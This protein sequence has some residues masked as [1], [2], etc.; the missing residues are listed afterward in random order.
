M[1]QPEGFE[2][3]TTD[4]PQSGDM[5]R[6]LT[7][8]ARRYFG[9]DARVAGLERLGGGAS[10]ELWAFT[11]AA[12]D[13]S[14]GLVLR[15]NPVGV[16]RAIGADMNTEARII[17]LAHGGGVPVPAILHVLEAPDQL[18]SGY[19]ME[20]VVGESL[21]PRILREPQ[22]DAARAKLAW[23]M[24]EAAARIHALA[25]ERLQVLPARR[26][27]ENI[28][29]LYLAQGVA[30]PVVEWTLRWLWREL[31]TETAA[32]SVVHGDFRNGNIMVGAEGLRAVLDW[33]AVHVGDPMEDL[34]YLCVP[35][36]RF[37][38]LDDP[39][40]GFGSRDALIAGYQAAGGTADIARMR[41]WEVMGTLRWGLICGIMADESRR[42]DASVEKA[43]IGRRASETALDLLAMLAP[44]SGYRHA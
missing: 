15:R 26:S 7:Q 40:G 39:V 19:I 13:A 42:G 24:G 30:R 5:S 43:A 32:L 1:R 8:L 28:G 11:V 27:L 22:Y 33:E 35:S 37:G 38:K 20:R 3:S 18:G 16:A 21:A 12:A 17:R 14:H 25:A 23:Q 31:P 10:Q 9:A 34:G 29:A 4:R 2:P 6:C 36:W 44:G 41:F